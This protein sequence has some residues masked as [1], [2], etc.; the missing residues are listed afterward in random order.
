AR[1]LLAHAGVGQRSAG[2]GKTEASEPWVEPQTG[3]RWRWV[4]GGEFGMGAEDL[5]HARPVHAVRVSPFWLAETPVTNDQYRRFLL[6]TGHPPSRLSDERRF[7]APVQP[8]VGVSWHDA[9][10][11]CVWASEELGRE[12]KLPSEAE[13]EFAARGPEGRKYPWG[14]Q[15]SD[16][17][18]AVYGDQ[19]GVP[20]EVGSC[21]AGRG[22][23]GHLDLAGNVWQW[24]RDVW[25]E[26][27]YAER[28]ARGEVVVDPEVTAGDD[29]RR[30][31]RGGSF[32]LDALDLRSA[33]RRWSHARDPLE[34]IGFRVMAV[35]A[36]RVG[37]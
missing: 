28:A 31:L 6:A 29:E 21:P 26:R 8:V 12:V 22:P 24:C 11:Y 20:R 34:S 36:S 16:A 10:A 32:W 9:A 7:N 15:E 2:S 17:T 27:A 35:P 19:E 1:G 25:N 30:C 4:P 14:E 13:W 3:L 33:L 37:D 23:Y 18:L 5:T